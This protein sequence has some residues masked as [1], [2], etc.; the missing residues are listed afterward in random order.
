L[1]RKHLA[2]RAH[3]SPSQVTK[4]ENGD[5]QSADMIERFADALDCTLDYLYERGAQYRN[6][7][8]AAIQMSFDVFARGAS[9]QHREWCRRILLHHD[10]PPRTSEA[11]RLLAEQVEIA[12]GSSPG[13]GELRAV[14]SR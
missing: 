6:A 12:A 8:D 4:H 5:A 2:E 11:W 9:D 3:A 13:G 7:T 14:R 10:S 1:E